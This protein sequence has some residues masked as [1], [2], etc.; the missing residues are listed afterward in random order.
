MSIIRSIL[1]GE[2]YYS[3]EQYVIDLFNN[4]REGEDEFYDIKSAAEDLEYFREEWDDVPES[5]TPETFMEYWNA[6][7]L[8]RFENVYLPDG[9][10]V[11]RHCEMTDQQ[12]AEVIHYADDWSEV[13]D[14]VD[15]LD[16]RYLHL[17]KDED[18][19]LKIGWDDVVEDWCKRN[20]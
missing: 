3:D 16:E 2:C 19:Y 7:V 13:E 14:L 5:L 12:I 20:M 11:P 15:Y 4:S 1:T 8:S 6:L 18:G 10:E 9:R 17:E